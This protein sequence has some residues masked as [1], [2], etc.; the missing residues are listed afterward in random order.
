MGL[1]LAYNAVSLPLSASC[2]QTAVSNVTSLHLAGL[3]R[4]FGCFPVL[5]S[6][7]V[8]VVKHCVQEQLGKERVYLVYTSMLLFII[9]KSQ[10]RNSTRVRILRQELME[11]PRRVLLL[12]LLF[13]PCSACFL[14][15]PGPPT[16]GGPT[17]AHPHPSLIKERPT[18]LPT[19]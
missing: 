1:G 11:R 18:G 10:S 16:M 12:G 3:H 14:I 4:L 9:E 5:V 15:E 13:M 7:S 2:L 8:A 19:A 6:V 17:W